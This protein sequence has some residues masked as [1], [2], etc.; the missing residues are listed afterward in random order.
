MALKQSR[1]NLFLESLSSSSREVHE[2]KTK[3]QKRVITQKILTCQKN[4]DDVTNSHN[5]VNIISKFQLIWRYVSRV[6]HIG[7]ERAFIFDNVF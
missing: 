7:H 2:R 6:L 4:G 5:N 3:F 1:K